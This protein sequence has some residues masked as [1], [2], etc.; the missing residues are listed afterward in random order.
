MSSRSSTGLAGFDVGQLDR[1]LGQVARRG[2]CGHPDG[3]IRLV[4]SALAEFAVERERHAAGWC[5]GRD[6]VLPVPP[7]RLQ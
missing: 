5:C 2:A 6:R 7:G 1:W 3:V 4:R